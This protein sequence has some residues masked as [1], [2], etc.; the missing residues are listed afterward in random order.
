MFRLILNAHYYRP[1]ELSTIFV[2][3]ESDEDVDSRFRRR[4][5]SL[6]LSDLPDDE[7]LCEL[8]LLE[9]ELLELDES[10]RERFDLL[11][12]VDAT[13]SSTRLTADSCFSSWAFSFSNV[14]FFICS[15]RASS[16]AASSRSRRR[17]ASSL[18][19]R[20]FSACRLPCSSIS[21]SI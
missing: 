11:L 17:S 8:R 21:L 15:K 12:T 9:L 4:F 16:W 6:R 20:S 2:Q 10:R 1:V 13:A 14:S 18:S 5:R 19:I 3:F 7:L